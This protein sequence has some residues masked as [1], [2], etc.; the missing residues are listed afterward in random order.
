MLSLLEAQIKAAVAALVTFKL[1]WKG[2]NWA[3]DILVSDGNMPIG[4]DGKPAPAIEGEIS[5]FHPERAIGHNGMLRATRAEGV[6]R[7]YL[8]VGEGTGTV[9]ITDEYDRLDAGLSRKT[10]YHNALTGVRIFFMDAEVEDDVAFYEE[11]NRLV[12]MVTIPWVCQWK[13]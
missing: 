12:R 6:V 13:S 4:V 7:L 9:G 2:D 11:A 8:S 1:R 5:G 10:I 3:S